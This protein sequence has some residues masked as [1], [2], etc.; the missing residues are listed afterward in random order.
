M[1][2]ANGTRDFNALHADTD[3][4]RLLRLALDEG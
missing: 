1:A 3:E 4:D 2:R